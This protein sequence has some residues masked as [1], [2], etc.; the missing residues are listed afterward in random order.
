MANKQNYPIALMKVLHFE[1]MQSDGRKKETS[2][3]LIVLTYKNNITNHQLY[4]SISIENRL[5]QNKYSQYE[6]ENLV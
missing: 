4:I 3:I 2:Q 1:L 5:I 6:V